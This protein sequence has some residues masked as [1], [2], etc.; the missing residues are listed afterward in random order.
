MA[1]IKDVFSLSFRS[2]IAGQLVA[3]TFHVRQNPTAGDVDATHLQSLLND[4]NTTA[5]KNAYKA[6]IPSTGTLDVL[7]ARL[8]PDPQFPDADRAEA[9][10]TIGEAGTFTSDQRDPPGLCALLTLGTDLAGRRFRG[11]VFMPPSLDSTVLNTGIF[12]ASGTYWTN[13]TAFIT[14]LSKTMYP[15][16]AGHYGGAWNDNDLCVYSL[17]ARKESDSARYYARVVAATRRQAPH[18][19]RSRQPTG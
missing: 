16:G 14:E 4:A 3:N 12:V 10:R 5:L 13:F 8:V 2:T 9:A 17:T 19:L 15:S 11:R 18:W 7:V 6:C 1:E